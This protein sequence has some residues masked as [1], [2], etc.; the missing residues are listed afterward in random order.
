MVP[1]LKQ[2]DVV[3]APSNYAKDCF[4][5]ISDHIKVQVIPNTINVEGIQ[6]KHY[7]GLKEQSKRICFL[8]RVVPDKGLKFIIE[9]LPT[10]IENNGNVYLDIIGPLNGEYVE[11]NSE[12]DFVSELKHL[13]EELL[14]HNNIIWHGSL[15]GENKYKILSNADLYI[16]PSVFMGETFGVTN[17][18]ALA[19]GVPVICAKWSGFPEIIQQGINGFLLDVI[20][21]GDCDYS[22]K[23]EQLIDYVSLCFRDKIL[24]KNLQ[25]GAIE[26]S[27]KYHENAVFGKFVKSLKKTDTVKINKMDELMNKTIFDFTQLFKI[28]FLSVLEKYKS[29]FV[30]YKSC[31][32]GVDLSKSNHLK[33]TFLE[34]IKSWNSPREHLLTLP[35]EVLYDLDYLSDYLNIDQFKEILPREKQFIFNYL[36]QNQ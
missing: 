1:F 30:S 3:F 27:F 36:N 7:T 8:G 20:Q 33:N 26:T 10:I 25:K 4:N 29:F 6:Q 28:G 34:L 5:K 15:L 23:N 2:E 12:S 35:E 22:I 19:C 17:I 18:E 32:E 13:A 21:K 31:I 24:L 9:S 14:V 11:N 16:N